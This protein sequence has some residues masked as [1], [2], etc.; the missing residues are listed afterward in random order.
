[1]NNMAFVCWNRFLDICEAIEERDPTML[2]STDFENTDVP[3]D[4]DLPRT[5]ISES[6]REDVRDWVLQVS[7]DQQVHQELDKRLC[8]KCTSSIYDAALTCFKCSTKS[9]ACIVTGYP[10]VGKK[11]KCSSCNK[12]ANKEDWNKYVS[13]EKVQNHFL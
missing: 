12:S 7:L 8:E 10:I 13:I 5:C 1:M 6:K 9:E 11:A 4:V 2:E 3:V